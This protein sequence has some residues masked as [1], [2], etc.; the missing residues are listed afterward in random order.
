MGDDDEKDE[1]EAIAEMAEAIAANHGAGTE[2][3]CP[4]GKLMSDVG[5]QARQRMKCTKAGPAQVAT[6][7]YRKHWDGIFGAKFTVGQA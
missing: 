5:A 2:H 3:A 4:L 6:E 7:S 1:H